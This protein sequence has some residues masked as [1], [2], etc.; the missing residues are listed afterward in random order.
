[1]SHE[2]WKRSILMRSAMSGSLVVIAPPSPKQPRF[3]EGKKLKVA[4]DPSDPGRPCSERDPAACAASSITGTPSA[5]ISATGATLPKRCTTTTA[6]VRGVSAAL[7]VSG[8]T[9][10]VSGSTSQKTGFAPV[11]GT[12]SALA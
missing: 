10:N 9:Q 3:L 4:A 2:P 11:G 7:T 1:M 8:V 12:A 6:L 5:S